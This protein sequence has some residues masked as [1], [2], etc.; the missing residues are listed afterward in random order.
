M[1]LLFSFHNKSVPSEF[2]YI[3]DML[4]KKCYVQYFRNT[5]YLEYKNIIVR[6]EGKAFRVWFNDEVI[7]SYNI[8]YLEL[9]ELINERFFQTENSQK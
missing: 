8:S 5:W 7:A 3:M 1:D 2:R 4:G 9:L 6:K